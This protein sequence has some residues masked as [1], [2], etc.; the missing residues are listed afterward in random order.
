MLVSRP[1]EETPGTGFPPAALQGLAERTVP[2]AGVSA[3][4]RLGEHN[5]GPQAGAGEPDNAVVNRFAMSCWSSF[6]RSPGFT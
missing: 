5:T 1:R 2:L 4:R 3:G 6:A